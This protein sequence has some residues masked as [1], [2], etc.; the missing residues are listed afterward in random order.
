MSDALTPVHRFNTHWWKREDLACWER[1]DWPS[2]AKVR[3]YIKMIEAQPDAPLLV[4]CSAFSAMQIY[5]A[6]AA[7][8]FNVRGIVYTPGRAHESDAT[9]YAREKGVEICEVRPCPGPN[10]YR[11]RAKERGKALGTFV[12]WDFIGALRDAQHQAQNI[13]HGVKRVLIPTGSGLIAAGVLAG[14]AGHQLEVVAVSG[15][16][17]AH[18]ETIIANASKL[19]TA[20]LP[21]FHLV[22]SALKYEQYRMFVLEDGTPLDPFYAAKV[23]PFLQEDDC[24]WLT[25]LRPVCSMPLDCQHAFRDWQGPRA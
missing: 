10:V 11:A 23:L 7:E 15:S 25:G 6:A 19:T 17:M 16:T 12:R 22:H 3:Q 14:L 4:G 9:R 1:L 20:T 8:K 18:A 13:P 2:G 5:I 24:V 21:A